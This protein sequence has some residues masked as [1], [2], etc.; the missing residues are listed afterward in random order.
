MGALALAS[1]RLVPDS[2]KAGATISGKE[3]PM[4]T[5]EL[6]PNTSLPPEPGRDSGRRT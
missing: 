3:H 6:Q 2:S 5:A 4:M 1:E